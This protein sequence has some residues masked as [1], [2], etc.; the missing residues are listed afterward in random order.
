[1][2]TKRSYYEVLGVTKGVS[3]EEIKSAYRKL[4]RQLHPDVNKADDAAERF[5]EVQEAYE[6]LSDEKKRAMYDRL[7]HAAYMRG[8]GAGSPSGGGQT[9]TWSN[10]GGGFGGASEGFDFSDISDVFGEMF[11]QQKPFRGGRSDAGARARSRPSK[12]RD[13]TAERLISFE[14]A[15]KGGKESVHISRGGSTQNIE[16]K[17]PKGVAPGARLRVRG[18]GEPSDSGAPPGDLILTIRIGSHPLFMRD[19]LDI[20]LELPITIVEATLGSEIEIPTPAG[21]RVHLKVPDG[22][23]SGTKLRLRSRGI[24]TEDGRRGDLYAVLKIVPPGELSGDDRSALE[25]MGEHL[26]SPRT[27]DEWK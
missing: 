19:G 26:P 14:T 10:V 16:V 24:E 7:G 2:P 9:Y 25:K 21:E 23:A 6:T 11:G 4:A 27:G 3:D 22:S 18:G 20:S 5:G 17:I 1:M 12:G 13:L 8:G 15:V